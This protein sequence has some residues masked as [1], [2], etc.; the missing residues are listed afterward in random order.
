MMSRKVWRVEGKY[1]KKK[2]TYPFRKELLGEKES[3]IRE[4]VLSELGSRHRVKRNAIEFSEI[5]EIKPEEATDL[6]IRK[7]LGLESEFE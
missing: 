6:E 2:R 7:L 4:K 5:V 3:H 1:Y